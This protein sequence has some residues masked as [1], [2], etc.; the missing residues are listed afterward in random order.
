MSQDLQDILNIPASSFT[1]LEEEL[2]DE[3]E[4]LS[5]FSEEESP[6]TLESIR[7]QSPSTIR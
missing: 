3:D 1:W 2:A 7:Q 6:N 4:L 5:Q